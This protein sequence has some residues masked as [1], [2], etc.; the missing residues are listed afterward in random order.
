MDAAS[1]D[2]NWR[3]GTGYPNQTD[4][5]SVWEG[6]FYRRAGG[7][8]PKPHFKVSSTRVEVFTGPAL[9]QV[10][11]DGTAHAEDLLPATRH[12]VVLFFLDENIDD[13]L[14]R[15][16]HWLISNQANRYERRA[17]RRADKFV[18]YLRA[19]DAHADRATAEQI[20]DV[21][22]PTLADA[23]PDY[24]RRKRAKD[25]LKQA[26]KLTKRWSMFAPRARR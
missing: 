22:F 4:S 12:M 3:T 6:E 11:D 5:L 23:Y 24:Q 18:L 7:P 19:L 9:I 13:Q 17:R 1:R 26:M 14:D 2:T 10:N 25:T 8:I 20:G 21:L 15:A 16:R